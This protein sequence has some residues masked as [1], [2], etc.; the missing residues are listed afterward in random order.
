M[1]KLIAGHNRTPL[2]DGIYLCPWHGVAYQADMDKSVTYGEDYFQTYVRLEGNPIGQK[3]NDFRTALSSAYCRTILDVGIG[4]GEFIKRSS[5]KVYGYDVNPHGVAWLKERGLYLD[6]Y[7][8]LPEY[9]EGVTLWDTME[10]LPDPGKLLD[11]MRPKTFV[12]VSLPIFTDLSR[13]TESK[14]YKPDEHY[15]YWTDWGLKSY[16]DSKG[17]NCVFQG[18]DETRA[19]RHSIASF[20][21]RKV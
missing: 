2:C 11:L 3:L 19:G 15:Y 10:H 8:G 4:S 9:V 21:F 17:F 6:P 7:V 16:F 18:D 20:A 13:L 1:D 14:H 12:F 5:I